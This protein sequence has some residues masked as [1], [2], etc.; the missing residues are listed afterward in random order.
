MKIYIYG[1]G[2]G[3]EKFYRI[4][5]V[6]YTEVL[7]FIDGDK[8]KHGKRVPFAND[9]IIQG[10]ESIN[11]DYD[12]IIVASTYKDVYVDLVCNGI[13]EDKFVFIHDSINNEIMNEKYEKRFSILEKVIK[14]EYLRENAYIKNRYAPGNYSSTIVDLQYIKNKEDEILRKDLPV[15]SGIDLNILEQTRLLS[16]FLDRGDI[17]NFPLNRNESLRYYGNNT[18]FPLATAHLLCHIINEFA[19]R[20]IIEVGSGFSSAVMLDMNEKVLNHALRLTFIEP[21]P[22]RL[23]TML[24]DGD[25]INLIQKNLQE[26]DL[27]LFRGLEEN[28]ILFIDSSHVAKTGNDVNYILFEILPI[29]KR[30]V[31]VHFH[32]VFFPFE[33]PKHWIYEGRGWNEDYILRAFLQYNVMYKILFWDSCLQKHIQSMGDENLERLSE[34][35]LRG[36][37]LFIQKQ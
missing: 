22:T 30:G 14:P 16:M 29:L 2:S 20:R 21:Y 5:M 26:V 18:W 28:D 27:E 1:T 6:S 37:S 7:G 34:R 24:K 23:K 9:Y 31:I 17:L 19:S 3:A 13:S 35:Y 25:A 8:E 10:I 33:Y 12:V 32:D 36:A 11:E 15:E 4:R